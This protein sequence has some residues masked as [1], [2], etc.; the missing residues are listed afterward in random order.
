MCV[1]VFFLALW[2][3]DSVTSN[4][5]FQYYVNKNEKLLWNLKKKKINIDGLH[6]E[7]PSEGRV[8]LQLFGWGLQFC[9]CILSFK[10]RANVRPHLYVDWAVWSFSIGTESPIWTNSPMFPNANACWFVANSFFAGIWGRK[11]HNYVNRQYVLATV[12]CS[13]KKD[14][15]KIKVNPNQEWNSSSSHEAL[16]ENA[17]A[18]IFFFHVKVAKH[19]AQNW[20]IWIIFKPPGETKLKGFFHSW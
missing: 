16:K 15:L 9:Q 1:G 20:H 12:C 2:E 18:F 6:P 7:V 17:D 11:R 10:S 5:P 19:M 4:C 8:R 14:F 13:N 3:L